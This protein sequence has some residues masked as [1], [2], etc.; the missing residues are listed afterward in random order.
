MALSR[1]GQIRLSADRKTPEYGTLIWFCM[2]F[3][4]GVATI[5]MFGGVA[6]PMSHFANPLPQD[7][8][9][10]SA[11]AAKLAMPSRCIISV[12]TPG[13]SLERLEEPFCPSVIGEIALS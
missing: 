2:L 10:G 5:L 12:R 1:Y 11:E 6:E 4:A 7:V 8:D 3:A 13:P 9:A